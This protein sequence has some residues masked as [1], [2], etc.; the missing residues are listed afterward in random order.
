[1]LL[2]L[3]HY[4]TRC[5]SELR[6]VETEMIDRTEADSQW[7]QVDLVRERALLYQTCARMIAQR[8]LGATHGIFQ[9]VYVLTP[10]GHAKLRRVIGQ[11][12]PSAD[13]LAEA[14]D[15]RL[16]LM[17]D[18]AESSGFPP[19]KKKY[20]DVC[21]GNEEIGEEHE[22]EDI[23]PDAEHVNE[24]TSARPPAPPDPNTLDPVGV[25]MRKSF[26]RGA[27]RSACHFEAIRVDS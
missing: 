19:P 11:I 17:D 9:L 2:M 15:Q 8:T 25:D 12:V 10:K 14:E 4:H 1:M 27:G 22:E 18:L 5:L 6:K 23:I 7:Y 26:Q 13:E 24:R 3:R 21:I 16:K 20:N